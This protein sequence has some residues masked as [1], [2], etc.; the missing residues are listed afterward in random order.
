MKKLHLTQ[1]KV[2]LVD[3]EDF[4]WL[5]RWKWSYNQNGYAIRN[6]K[7]RK[8]Q[9]RHYLHREILQADRSQRVDHIDGDP[10]NNQ[11]SNLRICSQAENVQNSRIR[12]D[13]KSGFKGVSFHAR[14]GKWQASICTK[15][16]R[17]HLG[18]FNT[19]EEAADAYLEASKLHHGEFSCL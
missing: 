9:T 1:G 18:L 13:N 2:A 19:V 17:N 11:R 8:K 7:V 14:S 5:S 4:E 15:G 6:S 16:S 12:S 10:L 3:D